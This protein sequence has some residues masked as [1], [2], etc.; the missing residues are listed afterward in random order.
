MT[1]YFV[2]DDMDDQ[3][4][5]LRRRQ[6]DDQDEIFDHD[7]WRPTLLIWK[8]S[9]GLTNLVRPIAKDEALGRFARAFD[10]E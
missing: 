3:P 5:L 2:Y 1:H 8:F 4:F 7:V 10:V 9:V 6:P